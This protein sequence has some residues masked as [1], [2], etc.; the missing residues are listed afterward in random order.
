MSMDPRI[1]KLLSQ[2]QSADNKPS[3]EQLCASCPELTGQV[4]QMIDAL[5]SVHVMTIA[6]GTDQTTLPEEPPKISDPSGVEFPVAAAAEAPS[7]IGPYRIVAV[8]GSGGMGV[9]YKAEQRHPVK[10]LVAL[11]LIK[12]GMDTRH[13][14]AR[15]ESER[16][17]LA[18]M[19]HPNI[20]K[21]IDAGA[22][23]TGR[24]YFV[25][26]YVP[27]D[28][29]TDYC[30]KTRLTTE[31]RL[32]LFVQVCDAMQHAHQKGIIHR[33]L[34]P[35]N[36]LVEFRDGKAVPK[37][38]DFGIAKATSAHLTEK[39]LYTEHGQ[40][41]GTPDYASPEQAESSGMDVD[42]RTDIYSLGVIL[43]ELLTG[44][45][46][47][48]PKTLRS[49]GYAGMQRIIREEDP[50][51]PS[52][53]L[54]KLNGDHEIE[55]IA[56]RRRVEPRTLL[57]KIR[58]E[59]D[60]IIVRAMDK[61]RTR[62]YDS[63]TA[64]AQDIGRYLRDEPVTAGPPTA[65]YRVGKF[66]KRH[67]IGIS[68]GAGIAAALV[69]GLAVA[70]YGLYT[71]RAQRDRAFLATEAAQREADRSRRINEYLGQML[72]AVDPEQARI[73]N[74]TLDSVLSRGRELFGNDHAIIAA[75]LSSRATALRAAGQLDDA[76]RAQL[77][78]LNAY[79]AA[80]GTNH[81]TVAAALSSLGLIQSDRSDN[82]AAESSL[83]QALELKKQLF[84]AKSVR[85]AEGYEVLFM[86]AQKRGAS[87]EADKQR[88]KE[89]ATKWVEAYQN[90]V[91]ERDRRTVEAMSRLGIW[92]MQNNFHAEAE[93][94]LVRAVDLGR[95]VLGK[96]HQIVFMTMNS[97][98]QLY[99][100]Q[101]RDA[102]AR[103]YFMDLN[104][105]VQV[106]FGSRSPIVLQSA[107]QLG[108]FLLRNDDLSTAETVLRRAIETAGTAVPR[109]DG[110][111]TDLKGKLID[112]S[113]QRRNADRK[114]L[115]DFWLEY[116]E[117]RRIQYGRDSAKLV[118]PTTLAAR[119]LLEWGYAMDAENLYRSIL[120]IQ[121][122]AQNPD[123]LAVSDTLLGLGTTLLAMNSTA[124][125]EG[126][127]REAVDIRQRVLRDGDWQ[128][129]ESQSRL[130]ECLLALG[131]QDEAAPLLEDASEV[132]E[133]S[134][135]A[136]VEA[137]HRALD[138]LVK[139]YSATGQGA[140]AEELRQKMSAS[141]QPATAPIR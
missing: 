52:T 95:D 23:D 44:K 37:V 5:H 85:V 121:R 118:E 22:T 107:L 131:R 75:V 55:T 98:T 63:A 49:A 7:H 140:E 134:R 127:L 92:L 106:V 79:K 34:K 87:G 94:V 31:E 32:N 10:R 90:S 16:Q 124:Q 82:A 111:L 9:V 51:K 71:A 48:D 102:K 130:G 139:L 137:K 112:I 8:L 2:W 36:I 81:S 57:R 17:A 62:R 58:G 46:P 35:G 138:T 129:A 1:P 133:S 120:P 105:S 33:D 60:W 100:F 38:I 43:Y 20:A 13:V 11:K 70:V 12:L 74:V 122:N 135:L 59:L 104:E 110:V 115:R 113:L 83:S 76:E 91:G 123:Q 14:I 53:R 101:K 103:P 24:P 108:N 25:M 99:V 117:D 6:D 97:L 28:P 42:T 109:G 47:F 40:M 29:I 4:R 19:D 84:G 77:E 66:V 3:V 88:L 126:I 78:A 86:V 65:T 136:P 132:L 141:T 73:M 125:A 116:L 72:V 80:Y 64:L 39:T 114:W 45:L 41:V 69:V 93:P 68:A 54:T 26:E 56:K 89:L 128:I 15:F 96:D 61:D 50:P 30:D 119:T 67:I 27:G 18:V 21:V